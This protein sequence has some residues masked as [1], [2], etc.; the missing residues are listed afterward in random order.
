[1]ELEGITQ[2]MEL[3][4]NL[5]F[6]VVFLWLFVREMRFHEETRR[7]YRKD[8]REIAGLRMERESLIAEEYE[9]ERAPLNNRPP[10]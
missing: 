9:R 6:S 10:T 4:G 2:V 3:A 8:L 5:G 1:M 7:E